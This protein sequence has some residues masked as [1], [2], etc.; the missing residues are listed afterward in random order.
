MRHKRKRRK[1]NRNTAHRKALM[2]NM[3]KN[4]MRAE[5]INTT[6]AKAKEAKRLADRIITL[7][8]EDSLKNKRA[9]YDVLQDHAL[10]SR[11]FKDIGPRFKGRAGGYTRIIHLGSRRGDG[12]ELAILSLVEIKAKEAHKKKAKKLKRTKAEAEKNPQ[13]KPSAAKEKKPDIKKVLEKKETAPEKKGF[14]KN[15][16]TFLRKSNRPEGK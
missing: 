5:S 12:A 1:L 13:E 4:L 11:V 6:L 10:V 2:A 8:K 14:M 16:R 9:V 15:L 7:A 3:V